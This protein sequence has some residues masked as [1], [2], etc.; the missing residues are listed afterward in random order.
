MADFVLKKIAL[1]ITKESHRYCGVPGRYLWYIP[2]YFSD[3]DS[4][5]ATVSITGKILI[6]EN[7]YYRTTDQN[8]LMKGKI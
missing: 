5:T 1:K 7:V 2:E 6:D 3:T 4:R 8:S